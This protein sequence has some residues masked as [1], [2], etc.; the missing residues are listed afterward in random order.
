M[1]GWMDGWGDV[2]RKGVVGMSRV[3]KSILK[4]MVKREVGMICVL[5]GKEERRR[6]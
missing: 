3:G 2:R 1:W 5:R 4:R 6:K